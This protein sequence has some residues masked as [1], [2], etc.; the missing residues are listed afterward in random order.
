MQEHRGTPVH[1]RDVI[2]SVEKEVF[3]WF[4]KLA[5][6]AK[7]KQCAERRDRGGGRPEAVRVGPDGWVAIGG[8]RG[9][10]ED[11]ACRGEAVNQ[12]H[13]ASL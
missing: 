9:E 13:R 2:H 11:G 12:K 4:G 6:P 1:A 7:H 8:H 5:V 10:E 3:P